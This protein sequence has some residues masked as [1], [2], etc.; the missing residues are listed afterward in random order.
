[1]RG[2]AKDGKFAAKMMIKHTMLLI[3]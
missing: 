2:M 3:E 1:M